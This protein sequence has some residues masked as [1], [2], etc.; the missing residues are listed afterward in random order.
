LEKEK[1]L[2]EIYS[3]KSL[4][5][6]ATF[7]QNDILYCK[8]GITEA[9]SNINYDI[10]DRMKTHKKNISDNIV[11]IAIFP[12]NN[13]RILENK[14][15]EH[16]DIK[17]RL[18]LNVQ[19]A[20]NKYRK[21]VIDMSTLQIDKL[22]ELTYI[23]GE[24][25]ILHDTND[26]VI[27]KLELETTQMQEKTK[28][29]QI[30]VAKIALIEKTKQIQEQEKTK[31]MQI[32]FQEK[33]NT[34]VSTHVSTETTVSTN[35]STETNVSTNVSTSVS[36]ETN[37]STNV[38]TDESKSK[39]AKDEIMFKSF[40]D[41][42]LECTG[43]SEHKI[44]RDVIYDY[45]KEYVIK[46]YDFPVIFEKTSLKL[47]ILLKKYKNDYYIRSNVK[48]DRHYYLAHHIFRNK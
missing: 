19:F 41:N 40:L 20:D 14:L 21:E 7:T 25:S 24:K 45:F 10:S 16:S 13:P 12:L 34:P 38:S 5:Y 31:Q 2:I 33:K 39:I 8:F 3:K 36:T 37:V 30:E 11:L 44:K 18:A 4:L 42:C 48:L 29:M 47:G 28:Q 23:L 32:E 22:V 35:V 43:N 26:H 17:T 46:N 27:R 9:E 6:L 1:T 15:K